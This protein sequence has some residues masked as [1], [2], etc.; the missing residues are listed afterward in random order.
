MIYPF[1]CHIIYS[2]VHCRLYSIA[3]KTTNVDCR[4]KENTFLL[5]SFIYIIYV[6]IILH[7][8][9]SENMSDFIEIARIL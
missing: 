9:Y 5:T 1:P 6:Y 3:I 4:L 8:I 7:Q 2:H